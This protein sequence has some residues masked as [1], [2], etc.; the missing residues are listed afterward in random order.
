M[1]DCDATIRDKGLGC[2]PDCFEHDTHGLL[3][4]FKIY[5]VADLAQDVQNL[6]RLL[7]QMVIARSEH[8]KAIRSLRADVAAVIEENALLRGRVTDLEEDEEEVDKATKHRLITEALGEVRKLVH[9]L[10]ERVRELEDVA[11]ALEAHLKLRRRP[12]ER[13]PK[14]LTSGNG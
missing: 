3:E 10:P 2:C 13:R 1:V 6:T 11:R 9:D 7:A 5:D 4:P 12:K 14:E 8:A